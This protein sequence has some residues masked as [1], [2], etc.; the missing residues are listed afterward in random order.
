MS[1]EDKNNEIVHDA[2]NTKYVL[3]VDGKEAGAA[4]YVLAAEGVRDFNHTV[5]DEAFQGQ[6]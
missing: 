2:E 5:V 1:T 3:K 6:G 4:H